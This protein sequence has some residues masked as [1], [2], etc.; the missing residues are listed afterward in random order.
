MTFHIDSIFKKI[1]TNFNEKKCCLD[2][3]RKH[4]LLY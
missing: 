4:A 1:K 3:K 2:V